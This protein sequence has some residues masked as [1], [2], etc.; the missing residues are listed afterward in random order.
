MRIIKFFMYLIGV[1]VLVVLGKLVL[2][3]IFWLLG[4]IGLTFLSESVAEWVNL[5]VFVGL[6]AG[7]KLAITESSLN[8]KFGYVLLV[9]LVIATFL[10]IPAIEYQQLV[11]KISSEERISYVA[12]EGVVSDYLD[13]QGKPTGIVGFYLAGAEGFWDYTYKFLLL[14][15]SLVLAIMAFKRG[16]VSI[17]ETVFVGFLDEWF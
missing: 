3:G 1:L 15:M 11:K 10:I 17:I 16:A 12:A 4:K 7:I 9:P 8:E 13:E 6:G 14:S 5:I 2:W